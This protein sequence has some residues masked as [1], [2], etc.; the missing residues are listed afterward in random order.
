[1]SVT[2]EPIESSDDLNLTLEQNGAAVGALG[3][4]PG[5]AGTVRSSRSQSGCSVSQ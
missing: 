3:K 4:I 5:K 1:M 2:V